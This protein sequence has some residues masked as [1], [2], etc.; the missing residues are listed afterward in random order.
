MKLLGEIN[1]KKMAIRERILIF[2]ESL[3]RMRLT[4][5]KSLIYH[6]PKVHF[7]RELCLLSSMPCFSSPSLEH[8]FLSSEFSFG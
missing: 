7:S 5:K 1:P 3:S 2:K 4:E 8:F 6:L